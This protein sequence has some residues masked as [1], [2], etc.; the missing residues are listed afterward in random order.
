MNA[1]EKDTIAEL[2]LQEHVNFY[3]ALTPVSLY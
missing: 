3:K 1:I 2:I